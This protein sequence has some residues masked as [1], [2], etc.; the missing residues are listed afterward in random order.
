[1][2]FWDTTLEWS[3]QLSVV[4]E[5]VAKHRKKQE[6]LKQLEI[7]NARH[8]KLQIRNLKPDT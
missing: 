3:E 6:A 7:Q 4:R 5:A 2:N 8:T 1:M